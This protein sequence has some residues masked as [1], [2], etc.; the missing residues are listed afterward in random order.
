[1]WHQ[2]QH[3]HPVMDEDSACVVWN[4]ARL[5]CACSCLTTSNFRRHLFY[6]LTFYCRYFT[7]YCIQRPLFVTRLNKPMI[8]WLIDW[9]IQSATVH[10]TYDTIPI[11]LRALKSW[12]NGQLSPAHGTETTIK[13]KTENKNP[14]SSEETVQTKVREASPGGRSESTRNRICETGRFEAGSERERELWMSRV[15][16]QRKKKWWVK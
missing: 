7:V 1:M 6:Y 3:Q 11:Y 15:V 14:I 13:K 12:Q 16:N 9:S 5:N 8:D 2:H 4:S 10:L